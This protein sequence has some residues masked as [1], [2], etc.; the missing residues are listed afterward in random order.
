MKDERSLRVEVSFPVFVNDAFMGT[1]GLRTD[2]EGNVEPFADMRETKLTTEIENT[3]DG[4]KN[5]AP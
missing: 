2:E 5:L 1:I 3:K 4:K